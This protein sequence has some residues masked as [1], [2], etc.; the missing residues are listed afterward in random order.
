MGFDYRDW[1]ESNLD[2]FRLGGTGE[3]TGTCPWCENFGAFYINS[4]TGNYIC[5]KCEKK[6]KN[7]IGVLSIIENISWKE[8]RKRIFSDKIKF[9]RRETTVSLLDKIKMLRSDEVVEIFESDE[10]IVCLPKEFIP[11]Y[12]GK[13]WSFP[14]YLK[15][16]GIDRKTAKSFCVGYCKN[17]YY[18]GRVILPIDCPNGKSFTSRALIKSIEPKMLNPKDI[19]NGRLLFG[20]QMAK[21]TS[22]IAIVEGPFDVMKWHQYGIPSLGLMG[23]VL[24]EEQKHLLFSRPKD[25][26]V[27][28]AV[29]P[30]E[31]D[32]KYDIASQLLAHFKRVYLATL[33]DGIDPGKSTKK[34]AHKAYY[35][36]KL[37]DG[38]HVQK[39]VSKFKSSYKKL[40]NAYQ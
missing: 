4:K 8:A 11:V 27:T 17:G 29:D 30:E 23:K 39:V 15:K 26:T 6:G 1:C 13:K 24:H 22:D 21:E 31:I 37:Y 25:S 20:W 33:P 5:H 14:K 16:R 38:N 34:Q 32:A 28:I 40:L 35:S 12:D 19:D 10:T 7:L 36:A 9:R 3:M 2:S 18:E